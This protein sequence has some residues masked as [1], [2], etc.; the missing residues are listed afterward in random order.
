M[1]YSR[2]PQITVCAGLIA[3]IYL[4]GLASPGAADNLPPSVSIL[5]P[6]QGMVFAI[7]ARALDAC[8]SCN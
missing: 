2:I 4:A 1:S 3:L 8:T 7:G 6:T 5:S